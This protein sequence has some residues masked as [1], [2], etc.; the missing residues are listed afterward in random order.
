[1]SLLALTFAALLAAQTPPSPNSELEKLKA[2]LEKQRSHNQDLQRQL[3]SA[4]TMLNKLE[5]TK[6][7]DLLRA[8]TE[9]LQADLA[10]KAAAATGL[11]RLAAPPPVAPAPP[12]YYQFAMPESKITAVANER[13]AA[14]LEE[15]YRRYQPMLRSVIMRVVNNHAEADE[16][17]R[18]PGQFFE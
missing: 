16:D 7:Y 11:P 18:Q 3:D 10:A 17:F 9:K 6:A 13:S 5:Q 14:A 8:E 4:N 2:E 15:I 1:M 12:V